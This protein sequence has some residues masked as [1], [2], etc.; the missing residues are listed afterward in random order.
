MPDIPF[1]LSYDQIEDGGLVLRNKTDDGKVTEIKMSP[2]QVLGLKAEIDLWKDRRWLN[3]QVEA[4]TVRP[5][6]VR[7]VSRVGV[8]LDELRNVVLTVQGPSGGETS[9][10]LPLHVA[11]PLAV[12]LGDLVQ[13]LTAETPTKQ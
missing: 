12:M 6:A 5:I 10:G 2:D 11:I 9:L 3:L 1:G 13:G 8:Q 4:G 7:W